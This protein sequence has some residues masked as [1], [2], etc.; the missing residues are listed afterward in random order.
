[1]TLSFAHSIYVAILFQVLRDQGLGKYCDPEFV[2]AASREMQE[3]MDMTQEEF[4]EAAHRLLQAEQEGT[5][6]LPQGGG[7]GGL[8]GALSGA[9]AAGAGGGAVAGARG[10]GGWGQHD[11]YEADETAPLRSPHGAGPQVPSR[12]RTNRRGQRGGDT[13]V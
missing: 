3:A 4:D 11:A 8:A 5:I 13:N 1:M 7:I 10:G 12:S 2:R 9:G 6:R